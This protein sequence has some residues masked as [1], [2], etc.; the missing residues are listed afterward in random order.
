MNLYNSL[1]N[2]AYSKTLRIEFNCP[3][4]GN[5]CNE[6]DDLCPHCSYSLEEYKNNVLAAYRYFNNAINLANEDDYFDALLEITK[7][8]A[9]FPKDLDGNKVFV[10]L[11]FKNKQQEKY[12]KALQEFENAFPRNP[13][14]MEVETKGIE[15]YRLPNL[16]CE[17]IN[18]NPDAFIKFTHEY[19]AY[20]TK[21]VK[22]T[23]QLINE[24][25]DVLRVYLERKDNKEIIGFYETNFLRFL[26]KKEI[27]IETH[28][29]QFFDDISDEQKQTLEMIGKTKNKKKKNGTIITVYPA[30]YLRHALL[31]KERIVIVDNNKKK[32]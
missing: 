28:N 30:I 31:S 17:S 16:K 4:C 20:R 25:Y 22:E 13:W 9:F 8:L 26:S 2:T 24:F 14:I 12:E 18:G 29:S 19:I 21:T 6:S 11:L 5:I 10:Y 3:S 7:F 23:I 27:Q 1:N 32:I 15:N